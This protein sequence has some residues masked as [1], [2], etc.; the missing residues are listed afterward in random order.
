[1]RTIIIVIL[2][3]ALVGVLYYIFSNKGS[4]PSTNS[5]CPSS[6]TIHPYGQIIQNAVSITYS[7]SGG[8]YYMQDAAGFGGYSAGLAPVEITQEV[9][10]KACKQYQGITQ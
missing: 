4:N 2:V 1:M 9:F 10:A 5:G 3:L 7:T 6:F 8:K